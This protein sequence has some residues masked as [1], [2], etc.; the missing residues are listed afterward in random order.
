VHKIL[1]KIHKYLYSQKKR[2]YII[3]LLLGLVAVFFESFGYISIVPLITVLINPDYL[4]QSI[5]LQY[6]NSLVQ[7][8]SNHDFIMKYGVFCIFLFIFG[9]IFSFIQVSLQVRFVNSIILNTRQKLLKNYLNKDVNF[10]KNNNTSN[11]ISKLFTQIDEMGTTVIFGFFDF[12]NSIFLVIIFLVL[13]SVADWKLTIS[14]LTFL[15]FF[16]FLIELNLK[17]K[18]KQIAATLYESNLKALSFATEA[19]KLFKEISLEKQK[20]FFLKRFYNEI[21]K[22]YKARNFV[23]IVPRFSRFLIETIGIGSIIIFI[24][25]VY[26]KNQNVDNFLET[27]ILFSLSVYK[28]FPNLNK[29]FQINVNLK[30]G[31]K[32]LF[33]ILDD[34]KSVNLKKVLE[35]EN[36][37]FDNAIELRNVSFFY[38]SK[39]I[40]NKV[41][42]VIKKNST[43]LIYGKSG[44]GK[45]TICDI[46]SGHL[47]IKYGEILIDKNPINLCEYSNIQ[48][49]Y[50]YIGQEPLVLNENFYR[51]IS[52]QENYDKK[53]VEEVARIS[54]IDEFINNKKNKYD[55]IIS[56]NGKNLSGGQKQRIS[57]ARALYLDPEILIID[58]GT[59]N[60]DVTTEKEIYELIYKNFP[61]KTKIIITHHLNEFIKYDYCYKISQGE[62]IYHGNQAV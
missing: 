53:K 27:I 51:N 54:R 12:I 55:E 18:I 59:S 58:E 52:L 2:E 11:L 15:S 3:F 42:I 62:V 4:Q 19:I 56:E 35:I 26:S 5:I 46:I 50:G 28:I 44:S 24:L 30:S 29:C 17:K 49:Y 48:R 14:A 40:I 22:I 7:S 16:Y 43:I 1:L 38:G 33:S 9:S 57:V 41:N 45:S 61:S 20:D 60:I 47:D 32:Q 36:N 13:L 31:S 23:R 10:Y 6:I 34:I 25:I 8:S 37:F 39:Q 21:N